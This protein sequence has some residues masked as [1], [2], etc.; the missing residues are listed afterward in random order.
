MGAQLS[1]VHLSGSCWSRGSWLGRL[2]PQPLCASLSPVVTSWEYCQGPLPHSTAFILL[3]LMASQLS[4]RTHPLS[5]LLLLPHSGA[6]L[7]QILPPQ[8]LHEGCFSQ[9]WII[10]LIPLL[11]ATKIGSGIGPIQIRGAQLQSQ[12]FCGTWRLSFPL[13]S[14]SWWNVCP[15]LLGPLWQESGHIPEHSVAVLSTEAAPWTSPSYVPL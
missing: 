15:T 1:W 2:P 8:P 5:T 3:L 14:L 4:C 11:L 12:N 13:E 7:F 6:G 9:A 10:S